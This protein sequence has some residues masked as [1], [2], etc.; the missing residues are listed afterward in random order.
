ME[1][2]EEGERK[3]IRSRKETSRIQ[4]GKKKGTEG[5]EEL[6]RRD[7]GKKDGRWCVG[8]RRRQGS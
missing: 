3:T 4:V 6:G 7:G 5:E 2:K 8:R 1:G